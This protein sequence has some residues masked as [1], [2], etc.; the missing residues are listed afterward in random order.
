MYIQYKQVYLSLRQKKLCT[1]RTERQRQR[2]DYTTRRV[3]LT[4]TK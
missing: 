2:K 3:T 1:H 4:M